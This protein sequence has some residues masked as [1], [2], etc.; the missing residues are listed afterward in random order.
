MITFF[1]HPRHQ[2][3]LL[4]HD[5]M[6][7]R[8]SRCR[9]HRLEGRKRPERC[10]QGQLPRA[11]TCTPKG[12]KRPLLSPSAWPVFVNPLSTTNDS[13]PPGTLRLRL[14]RSIA[15]EILSTQIKCVKCHCKALPMQ[16]QQRCN[17]SR[18]STSMRQHHRSW[19]G[20]LQN[21]QARGI[22]QSYTTAWIFSV[23]S[24][25]PGHD[26]GGAERQAHCD[27]AE[28]EAQACSHN[29]AAHRDLGLPIWQL[30]QRRRD[31]AA[32]GGGLHGSGVF[33][34][35]AHAAA[36]SAR[37]DLECARA[38]T[39]LLPLPR[40][41]CRAAAAAAAL[42]ACCP[43]NRRARAAQQGLTW[44]PR[45]AAAARPR[46]QRRALHRAPRRRT[47]RWRCRRCRPPPWRL[48]PPVHAD[49]VPRPPP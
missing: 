18:C 36:P 34:S 24:H 43:G 28:N 26:T 4:M 30:P 21:R 6:P 32:Q 49:W 20:A 23:R 27:D 5:L 19:A 47:H 38:Q 2:H 37:A 10:Y 11:R 7:C 45:G 15:F 14:Q 39:L 35:C 41:R 17:A 44:R 3:T 13:R 29:D 12:A 40:A 22:E 48:V 8:P 16:C 33:K 9:C 25:T 31:R 46:R 1:R 42:L